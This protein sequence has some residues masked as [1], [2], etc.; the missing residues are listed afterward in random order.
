MKNISCGIVKCD[1]TAYVKG[2]YISESIRMIS[3][4][5]EYTEEN[6]ISGMLFSVDFEKASDLIEQTVLFTVLKSF[7]LALNLS[8]G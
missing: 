7:E 5:L 6:G 2:R 1:Q 3:D 8:S 4:I